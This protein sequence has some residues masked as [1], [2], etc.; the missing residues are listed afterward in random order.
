MNQILEKIS[1]TL[2][3]GKNNSNENEAQ[4]AILAA[5]RLMAKYHISQEEVDNFINENK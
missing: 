3:L 4:T 2:Q 1:K 5:Q